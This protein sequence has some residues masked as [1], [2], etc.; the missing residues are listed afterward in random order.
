MYELI[1]GTE[2]I[3]AFKTRLPVDCGK[4]FEHSVLKRDPMDRNLS[5]FFIPRSTRKILT[6]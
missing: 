5:G 2:R 6:G 4:K 1:S 3:V